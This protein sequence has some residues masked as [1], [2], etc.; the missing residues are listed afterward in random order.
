MPFESSFFFFGLATK[1]L[2]LLPTSHSPGTC[3]CFIH[4]RLPLRLPVHPCP[5]PRVRLRLNWPVIYGVCVGHSTAF[6]LGC[7]LLYIV[8]MS[9][10]PVPLCTLPFA[11][12]LALVC[13]HFLDLFSLL[14]FPPPSTVGNFSLMNLLQ[15]CSCPSREYYISYIVPSGLIYR[16]ININ[17]H[18]SAAGSNTRK[19]SELRHYAKTLDKRLLKSTVIR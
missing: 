10:F 12:L 6:D 7:K 19:S 15:F 17:Y 1:I 18:I 2:D 14:C 4:I 9:A 16:S 3:C 5:S 11:T 8:A 13:F